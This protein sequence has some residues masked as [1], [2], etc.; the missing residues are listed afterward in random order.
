MTTLKHPY[1][2]TPEQRER[3]RRQFQSLLEMSL[4]DCIDTLT[5]FAAG[6]V[7]V[8]IIHIDSILHS[9]FGDY[10][11]RGLSMNDILKEQYGETAV[12]LLNELI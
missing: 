9:R 6:R 3:L 10:E 2:G 12:Q 1:P 11:D 8:D 4:S 5:S 7:V